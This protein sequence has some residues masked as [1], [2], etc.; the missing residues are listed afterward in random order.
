MA[1]KQAKLQFKPVYDGARVRKR[2]YR[3]NEAWEDHK[4]FILDLVKNKAKQERILEA[5][6]EERGFDTK[7]NQL[8]RQL[9]IWGISK[10]NLK[11]RQKKWL[12]L[13]NQRREEEGKETRFYFADTGLEVGEAQV[14]SILRGTEDDY[15]GDLPASPGELEFATP[16]PEEVDADEDT[17]VVLADAPSSPGEGEPPPEDPGGGT[18]VGQ[19]F[20]ET[21]YTEGASARAEGSPI[22]PSPFGSPDVV[23]TADTVEIIEEISPDIEVGGA[24]TTGLS[25]TFEDIYKQVLETLDSLHIATSTVV[26]VTPPQVEEDSGWPGPN[27]NEYTAE[28]GKWMQSVFDDAHYHMVL[29]EIM[30]TKN[31][32][33][34]WYCR[35]YVVSAWMSEYGEIPIPY[36]ICCAIVNGMPIG[37]WV[38]GREPFEEDYEGY[39]DFI[40]CNVWEPHPNPPESVLTLEEWERIDNIHNKHYNRIK[41]ACYRLEQ[42]PREEDSV[43]YFRCRGAHL[44]FLRHTFGELNYF[45]VKSL[46][47]FAIIFHYLRIS[48]HDSE[49]LL[50]SAMKLGHAVGLTYHEDSLNIY[51]CLGSLWKANR[52][53][54]GASE[55]Y[56]NSYII[57]Q[58]VEGHFAP[59]T[60]KRISN[61]AEIDFR[62]G[63]IDHGNRMLRMGLKEIQQAASKIPKNSHKKRN[64]LAQALFEIARIYKRTG[65][66]EI[67]NVI[68]KF[69]I[70]EFKTFHQNYT[71]K[72]VNKGGKIPVIM[73]QCYTLLKDHENAIRMYQRAISAFT[74][75]FGEQSGRVVQTVRRICKVMRRRG[76]IMYTVPVLEKMWRITEERPNPEEDEVFD[77]WIDYSKTLIKVGGYG[78]EFSEIRK[79]L[80]Y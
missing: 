6:K 9:G 20:K 76:L 64:I 54:S 49:F 27:A 61:I 24:P 72:D 58:Y 15:P 67:A 14:T 36:H 17:D 37:M 57:F 46:A 30:L 4:E 55:C 8:K 18:S 41:R 66:R 73:A 70:H 78:S 43:E 65:R 71:G 45:T 77:L 23:L 21:N 42:F 74:A 68:V 35:D 31:E 10:R 47:G 44:Q 60:I 26:E 79:Q 29:M 80:A 52:N 62:I 1:S 28:L 48:E 32:H 12:F 22:R 11:Q 59:N 3:K 25:S 63:R 2:G 69:A 7:L 19:N 5:L 56:Q 34:F 53:W 13:T 75:V 50:Q 33:P 51:D 16:S 38:N 39:K 40:Q